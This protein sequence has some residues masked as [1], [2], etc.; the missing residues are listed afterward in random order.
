MAWQADV[1][2]LQLRQDETKLHVST[3]VGGLAGKLTDLENRFKD[4]ETRVIDTEQASGLN[5]MDVQMDILGLQGGL[6]KLQDDIKSF[7]EVVEVQRKEVE[8][9]RDTQ[10]VKDSINTL[11]QLVAGNVSYVSYMRSSDTRQK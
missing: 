11:R 2:T 4:L 3:E 5:A 8:S 10:D 7:M 6:S 1:S 9:L